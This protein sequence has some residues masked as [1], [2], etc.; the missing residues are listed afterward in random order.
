MI[1]VFASV[2]VVCVTA[3]VWQRTAMRGST[4]EFKA[5]LA[6][7]HTEIDFVKGQLG[8]TQRAVVKVDNKLVK[9]AHRVGQ[10]EV[11]MGEIK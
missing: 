11:P 3:L 1:W 7:V 5:A 2:I 9:I 10:D 8:A 6:A 4:S